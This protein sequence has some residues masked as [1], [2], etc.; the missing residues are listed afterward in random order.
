MEPKKLFEELGFSAKESVF[1][2]ALLRLKRSTIS[3]LGKKT[4]MPRTTLYTFIEK[5]S[6]RGLVH[7]VRV[8]NHDE[9]EILAPDA[10]YRKVKR[11]VHDLKESL[12][13]L[14]KAYGAEN[15]TK[16][17]PI[18]A[19]YETHE[20]MKKAYETI[21]KLPKGERVY[22]IEGVRSVEAKLK[23]LRKDYVLEW[24]EAF[25]KKGV[26]IEAL[27]GE[28]ALSE[29]KKMDEAHLRAQ[30][31]KAVIAGLLPDEYMEFGADMFC[32]QN[33]VIIAI[34]ARDT[35]VVMQN[36][37]IAALFKGLFRIAQDASRKIDLN[38]YVSELIAGKIPRG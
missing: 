20:G 25:K 2:A 7:K 36:Q 38:A 16:N 4:G 5:L 18:V 28:G 27:T 21:L 34:P 8:G 19:Y 35:V 3:A 11:S 22:S 30:F 33:T 6:K 23:H 32:F 12:P 31:G 29:L 37:E 15:T 1:L 13:E 10:L 9:W 24:Q 26:I 14:E 17:R